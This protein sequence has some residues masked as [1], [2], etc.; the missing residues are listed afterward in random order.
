MA[1]RV[2]D[3]G[4]IAK[5]PL[6]G[7][8]D[9]PE[10]QPKQGAEGEAVVL[11]CS[12]T[13]YL[14]KITAVYLNGDWKELASDKYTV[15]AAAG[16][17]TIDASVLSAG[18]VKLVVDAT[19][20]KSQAVTVD[21]QKVLETGLK[22]SPDY[23][24]SE[25]AFTADENGYAEASFIGGNSEGDFLKNMK[26]VV[27]TDE[28]QKADNVLAKGAEGS[29]AVY[30][31]VSEDKK[32]ITL[33]NV[34]PGSYTVSITAEYYEDELEAEF[35]VKDGQP[36]EE[37]KEAPQV[38]KVTYNAGFMSF[39]PEHYRVTFE[40][41]VRADMEAY[42]KAITDVE[43]NGTSYKRPLLGLNSY[44]GPQYYQNVTDGTGQH[45]CLDLTLD[46]FSTDEN[47]EVTILADGYN[48]VIF[49]VD[50]DGQLV[51]GE[52]IEVKPAPK[53]KG[54]TTISAGEKVIL[55]CED[56]EYLEAVSK[57]YYDADEELSYHVSGS[58]LSIDVSGLESGSMV[59]LTVEADGYED[60]TVDIDVEEEAEEGNKAP[61]V[62]EFRKK[63]PSSLLDM[64]CYRVTF[65][66]L[67]GDVLTG[68]LNKI[69]SVRVGS[70]DYKRTSSF[71]NSVS[72]YKLSAAD[73]MY[74]AYAYDCLDLTTDGFAGEEEIEIVISA[75][76][77]EDITFTVKDG[78]PIKTEESSALSAALNITDLKSSI[79]EAVK[80]ETNLTAKEDTAEAVQSD[81]A[82]S[83][84]T[85]EPEEKEPAEGKTLDE[86]DPV[87]GEKPEESGSVQEEKPGESG[88]TQGEGPG[89]SG[90]AEG[91][92]PEETES[93]EGEN[94]EEGGPEEDG[95]FDEGGS[96][97]G[98][99][100][101]GGGA[102][103]ESTEEAAPSDAND[104]SGE[105]AE[106]L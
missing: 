2:T 94:P 68:Y 26:T 60:N 70:I 98:G 32:S 9:A 5:L 65:G 74:D 55:T 36:A 56:E 38:G 88:P 54:E 104:Q 96:S 25:D 69:T 21:Y 43:V 64:E 58:E 45:D 101:E 24:E 105:S 76:G 11:S 73:S 3:D 95:S 1:T 7:R 20:Y 84:K 13:E 28:N 35:T 37:Q 17:L 86:K 90:S 103:G 50:K 85:E 33:C 91:E 57:I 46:G 42:L 6:T 34:K 71:W 27:L 100:S 14:E 89:E 31:V 99:N 10:P 44:D 67:S 15:D 61:T 62:E 78:K 102:S 40:G 106:A 52:T 16:T 53:L 77:Y 82:N 12:N 97:G 23:P 79:L 72:E 75:D 93:A 22:L 47:T 49:I 83:E 92:D 51:T 66:G 39:T 48:D 29:D 8:P 18:E 59:T 4:T 80:A 41:L 30:Y 63:V 19:G 87:E 81:G